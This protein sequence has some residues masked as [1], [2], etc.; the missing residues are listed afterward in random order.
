MAQPAVSIAAEP[1]ARPASRW[2]IGARADLLWLMLPVLSGYLCLY[3]SV[4]LGVSSLLIWWFWNLFFNGP[5]F[6]ATLSRTYLDKQEWQQRGSLL[7]GSLALVLV[8]P[9]AIWLS[10]RTASRVPFLGFWFFGVLWAYYHVVRQHY[11]FMAL[12]QK[13]NGERAGSDN[14][15]DFWIFH[16]LMFGPVVSWLLRYP[17]LRE[18]AG[19]SFRLSTV[20]SAVVAATP[21]VVALT[22]GLYVVKEA[23][24]YRHRGTINWPKSLLLLAYVPLHLLL[25]LRPTVAGRYDI[26]L[27]NAV[28]TLPHNF[29][30]VAI[31]WF[32]NVNRYR[33]DRERRQYGWAS[34]AS[35][36]VLRFAALGVLY[37]AIFFYLR[38]YLEGQAVPFSFGPSR[39]SDLGLGGS[40]K[41]ADLA[42]AVWIGFVFHH[43]YLDQRIWKI[44]SDRQLSRDLLLVA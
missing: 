6:Y 25:L 20:E 1:D 35:S 34:V 36:S 16:V 10:V 2:I 37:S 21:L 18:A 26:L 40:F 44:H 41:I 39:W 42:A 19:L 23:L 13:K 24:I 38:W 43:Q 30:Y 8:G 29:Q 22:I 7:I 9:L 12:Y 11:G 32:Y 28:V 27:F 33:P 15:L 4:G 17:E 14:A 31:V 5:H 3:V